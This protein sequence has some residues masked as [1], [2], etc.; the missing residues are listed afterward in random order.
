MYFQEINYKEKLLLTGRYLNRLFLLTG[1]IKTLASLIDRKKNNQIQRIKVLRVCGYVFDQ[2]SQAS[3]EMS[4]T[5]SFTV[6]LMLIN[7]LFITIT[8][9]F[10][11][12]FALKHPIFKIQDPISFSSVAWRL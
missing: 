12:T 10:F 8:T 11:A 7:L 2:I 5:F 4:L 3:N 9:L 6:L 1:R